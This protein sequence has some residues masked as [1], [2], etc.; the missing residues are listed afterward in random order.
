VYCLCAAYPTAVGNDKQKSSG[1]ASASA[2]MLDSASCSLARQVHLAHKCYDVKRPG[3]RVKK[4]AR[5]AHTSH[6]CLKPAMLLDAGWDR[7][8]W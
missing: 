1:R 4:C 2:T 7:H 6:A 8:T 5:G 3:T